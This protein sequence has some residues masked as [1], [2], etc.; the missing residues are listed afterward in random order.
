[1]KKILV[2]GG[3]GYIGSHTIVDLIQNGYEV[4]SID[5]N[6]RSNPDILTGVESITGKQIKNYIVDLCNYDDT[7]NVFKENP[8][9]LGIIHFAA[10]KSVG[11]SVENPLIYFD[12]NLASLVN[13]LKC[14]EEF[15]V[16]NFVFSSS[17]TVYGN[18]DEI[19]VTENT[20]Q[21]PGESPYGITKQIGE[22]IITETIKADNIQT[23]RCS[24]IYPY[25]RNT[26]WPTG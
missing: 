18:P 20:P 19:P 11:E 12:N 25:R 15:N 17:C 3:C 14:S 6:S 26:H 9:I 8:D 1:M 4:I 5:N 23:R 24:S 2:T 10:Y 22:Q 16:S 7:K 21:K 13:I